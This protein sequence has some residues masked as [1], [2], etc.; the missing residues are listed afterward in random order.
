M[1]PTTT[2]LQSRIELVDPQDCTDNSDTLAMLEAMFDALVRRGADGRFIPALAESWTL[3]DDACRWTFRLRPGLRFHDGSPLD[4]EAMKY[5]IERMQRPDIGATLGAP[6]VWGQYLGGARITAPDPLTLTIETVEP[7]ADLL[8]ILVSGYALPPH[9]ADRPDFLHHPVGSGAFQF[10]GAEA[11]RE[12]RMTANPHW[13]GGARPQE[14]L[15]WHCVPLSEARAGAIAAGRAQIATRLSPVDAALLG[16]SITQHDYFDPTAI[17]YLLNAASG[18]F[19]DPRVRRAI[20]LVVDRQ[21]LIAEVLDGAGA[22]LGG[23]ISSAH[24]GAAAEPADIIPDLGTARALLAEAG[25]GDGLMLNVD[26]PT[27]LPDEAQALTSALARQ[28]ALIN[29]TLI[30]HTVEDR[31]AYAEQIRDKKIHDMCVFDS[32]PMSTFRVLYEKIDSRVRGSWWEGYR[33]DAVE[34][35]LDRSRRIVD[36]VAREEIHRQSYIALRQDPPWL[37]LYHH[38]FAAAIA[39][40]H[41]DWRMRADG[42]LDVTTLP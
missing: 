32:S 27:K 20:A 33:N 6:A 30:V 14:Q 35:L 2:I 19:S 25:Y 24:I 7:T 15:I 3:A 39:G 10:D 4:A 11:G 42:V 26:C 9:L 8:D 21:A 5:S 13:W 37:P 1:T 31:V 16:D 23:F 41:P 18:P 17:I 36:P 28:L 12:V 40:D 29:V 22:P 38:R 34:A